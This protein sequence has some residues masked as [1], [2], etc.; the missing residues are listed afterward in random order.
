MTTTTTLIAGL[1]AI[2]P[3]YLILYR[4]ESRL[5]TIECCLTKEKSEKVNGKPDTFDH[6]QKRLL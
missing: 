5:T 3:I 1:A 2:T 6:Y 4:V